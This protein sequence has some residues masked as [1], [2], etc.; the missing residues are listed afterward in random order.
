[1]KVVFKSNPEAYASNFG[2]LLGFRKKIEILG[3][4][5]I[6]STDISVAGSSRRV[7]KDDIWRF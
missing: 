5:G 7:S 4:I 2:K 6:C 3:L 1:M